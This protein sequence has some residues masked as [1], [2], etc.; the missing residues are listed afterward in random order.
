MTHRLSP[1]LA[2]RSNSLPHRTNS[3][4]LE[5]F[6]ISSEKIA[7]EL[8][9]SVKLPRS[10]MHLVAQLVG[11]T[12]TAPIVGPYCIGAA[13]SLGNPAAVM[14]WQTGHCFCSARYSCT[15]RRGGGTSWTCRRS[16]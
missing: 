4:L 15:S 13:T 6:L 2:C 16:T 1:S 9:E 8:D 11:Y 3:N 12:A 10:N 7:R 5:V 14:W